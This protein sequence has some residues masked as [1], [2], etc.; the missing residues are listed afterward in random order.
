VTGGD[1]KSNGKGCRAV[2]VRSFLV[3]RREYGEDEKGCYDHF[4]RESLAARQHFQV[5][6][7]Q[8]EI[9]PRLGT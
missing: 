2:Q 6:R 9:A 3:A 4:H 8:T 1:R 5:H 7:C